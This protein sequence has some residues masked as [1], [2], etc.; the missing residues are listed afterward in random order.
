M[1]R[2]DFHYDG[3][4]VYYDAIRAVC[5]PSTADALP[6][7]GLWD[8][9][10]EPVGVVAAG[11]RGRM[12]IFRPLSLG[13]AFL[14]SCYRKSGLK[15]NNRSKARLRRAVL[16][17]CRCISGRRLPA[18]LESLWLRAILQNLVK[19][20]EA[21]LAGCA[22]NQDQ[23]Q[24]AFRHLVR[25]AEALIEY[26]VFDPPGLGIHPPG[27][28]AASRGPVQTSASGSAKL[29]RA[30]AK[31]DEL[32]RVA[33][34]RQLRVINVHGFGKQADGYW[35]QTNKQRLECIGK[36]TRLREWFLGIDP[37]GGLQKRLDAAWRI[38]GESDSEQSRAQALVLA[39][40]YCQL[41]EYRGGHPAGA[42]S[43]ASKLIQAVREQ[44]DHAPAESRRPVAW[45]AAELAC[46]HREYHLAQDVLASDWTS[47]DPE[48]GSVDRWDALSAVGRNLRLD[49][50]LE[51][52]IYWRVAQSVNGEE[53][54]IDA[55]R[56]ASMAF[57]R[58][59]CPE[60]EPL[61]KDMIGRRDE[62]I[63]Q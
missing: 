20:A 2:H 15:T 44:M 5:S 60:W 24:E 33:L 19:Q 23:W 7:G 10:T 6:G 8:R 16:W 39:M 53:T 58:G 54:K 57:L 56:R 28:S 25:L 61:R 35:E 4:Q 37:A 52:N 29:V 41:P 13:L 1:K 12:I 46:D 3:I 34:A 48:G 63:T 27:A 11:L 62:S 36:A 55:Y 32:S 31:Y 49:A 43:A 9:T 47:M 42:G 17:V 51:G 21:R 45:K 22:S 26:H 50:Q 38:A 40:S 14:A 18:S 59:R 30:A